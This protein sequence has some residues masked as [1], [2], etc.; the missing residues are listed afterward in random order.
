[1]LEVVLPTKLPDSK[2][3]D[4][5]HVFDFIDGEMADG[6]GSGGGIPL[7]EFH[8]EVPPGWAPGQ[9]DYPLSRTS[10][11]ESAASG[12]RLRCPDGGMDMGSNALVRLSVKEVRDPA[13]PNVIL[14]CAIPSG[15]QA[16]CNSLREAFGMSDQD[17]VSRSI[18]DLMEFRR[19]KF[20]EYAIKW[21]IKMEEAVT[22]AGLEINGVGKLYLF[23]RGSGFPQEF[24]ENIK[25]QLQGSRAT[26]RARNPQRVGKRRFR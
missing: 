26:R 10:P 4:Y 7:H 2:C 23:F 3:P 15:V 17:L 6:H 16:L 1:M 19:G 18:E 14:Q 22:C 21:E 24:V 12:L 11:R 9:P 5:L 8:R 20:P 25:L 13:N